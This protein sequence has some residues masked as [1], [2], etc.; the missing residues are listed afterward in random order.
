MKSYTKT[1][2]CRYFTHRSKLV[3][4]ATLIACSGAAIAD[5]Q[6]GVVGSSIDLSAYVQESLHPGGTVFEED[7]PITGTQP[8]P[9]Q[10]A[11]LLHRAAKGQN[12][13]GRST[14]IHEAFAS[15]LAES[16]GNGGVGVSSWIAGDPGDGTQNQTGQLV[17]QSLWTQTF[18]YL[19][20]P[21]VDISLHLQIPALTVGLLGVPPN[22]DGFSATETSEATARL[23]SI[24]T[25][26]DGTF[27]RGAAWEF[28]LRVFEVQIPQAPG[29]YQN[30]ADVQFLGTDNSLFDTFRRDPTSANFESYPAWLV[31]SVS[32]S[33][34]LGSL[35]FGDTL[36]YVYTLTA[37]GTTHGGEHGYYAF[38]GD[39]FGVDI[40]GGN[41]TTTV[42][43]AVPLPPAFS[44]TL[45][46]L[47]ILG[48]MAHRPQKPS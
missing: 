45:I 26:A 27:S 11:E 16:D 4:T 1:F 22:R 44:L 29:V 12:F 19:G 17:A 28:G 15:S 48:W 34:K 46:G 36:A 43:P 21:K 38:L 9:K 2:N 35:E 42:T 8:S 32:T 7:K 41:L 6:F 24:I 14:D 47:G 37:K 25:H 30:F 20:S 18:Q 40:V 23:D 10:S 3:C 13:S 31:D 39:P 33:V 5:S